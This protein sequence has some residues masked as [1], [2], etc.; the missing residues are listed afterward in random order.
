MNECNLCPRNCKIDRSLGKIGF[1]GQTNQIRA[2]RAALHYWEEPCISGERGSGAVFFCGCNLGC[3]FCQNY[4]I[5]HEK[6]YGVLLS[7]ENL[8]EIYL[9][10][11]EKGAHNINLVTPSHYVPQIAASLEKAKIRGLHIPVVYNSSGYEKADTL[12]AL[13]GLVDIYLPDF[14]YMDETKAKNYSLAEDY[15]MRAKEAL[16][17]MVR[18]RESLQWEGSLLKKGVLV[19]HLVLPLGVGNAKRVLDYVYGTYGDRILISI[20]NQYTPPVWEDD[21]QNQN[22]LLLSNDDSKNSCNL[23]TPGEDSYKQ[24]RAERCNQFPELNRRVTKREYEQVLQYALSLGIKNAY[25]QEGE[26]AKESFIPSFL[27]EGLIEN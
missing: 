1:C 15:P 4:R 11:Q 19:R 23:L 2:A 24:Q 13:E 14:K 20:M 8:A 21:I 3:I 26:T 6:E 7:V 18:Q 22:A 25:F 10:L 16:A 27:G 12:K 5:A 9:K 17:E